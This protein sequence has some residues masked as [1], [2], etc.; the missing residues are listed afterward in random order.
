MTEIFARIDRCN[1]DDNDPFIAM[2][3][4]FFNNFAY[5]LHHNPVYQK[6][7]LIDH[8]DQYIMSHFIMTDQYKCYLQQLRQEHPPSSIFT[9]RMM[10][11]L[12]NLFVLFSC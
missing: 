11:Y 2:I 4:L 3:S 7:P 6:T 1:D 10:F 9:S 5:F 12:R 8:L